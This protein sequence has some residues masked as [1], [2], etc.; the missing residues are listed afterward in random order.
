MAAE[1]KRAN[2]DN[3]EGANEGGSCRMG[4]CRVKKEAGSRGLVRRSGREGSVVER[5]EEGLVE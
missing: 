5:E 2:G 4:R 1:R 3:E